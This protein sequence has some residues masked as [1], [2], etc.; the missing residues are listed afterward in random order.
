M[1]DEIEHFEISDGL[2]QMDAIHL[3]SSGLETQSGTR[4]RRESH[5]PVEGNLAQRVGQKLD[6]IG[7]SDIRGPVERDYDGGPVYSEFRPEA[8]STGCGER[9][10]QT[11][12]H[13]VSDKDDLPIGLSLRTK[14]SVGIS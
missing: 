5:G 2:G 3:E 14:L 7:V 9:I 11:V 6:A 10:E 8:G 4:V 13:H 12:N 1:F